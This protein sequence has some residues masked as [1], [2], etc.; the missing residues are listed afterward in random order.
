VQVG[1]KQ[2]P[3]VVLIQFVSPDDEHKVLETCRVINKNKYKERNLCVTLVVYQELL[4]DPRST[5]C[6]ILQCK[7]S[8]TNIQ[9]REHQ[10]KI[11]QE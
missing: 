8:N 3:E 10:N 5:E 11:V 1:N 7:T 6:K 2:L 4:H 9:I